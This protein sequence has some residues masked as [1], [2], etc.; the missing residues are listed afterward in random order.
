MTPAQAA[1]DPDVAA[2]PFAFCF[3][4]HPLRWAASVWRHEMEFGWREADAV[5]HDN[6]TDFLRWLLETRPE[7][8]CTASV[9]PYL[10]HCHFVGKLETLSQ[11]LCA[12]LTKAGE[13]FDPAALDVPPVNAS[14]NATIRSACVAPRE[15]L[16]AVLEAD[17]AFCRRFGYGGV[18]PELVGESVGSPWP[19]LR[20]RRPG[21]ADQAL[22]L[23]RPQFTY[24]LE[25]G[26]EVR[27]DPDRQRLQWALIKAIDGLDAPGRTAVVSEVDAYAAYLLAAKPGSDVTFVPAD[28][29]VTPTRLKSQLLDQPAILD[30]QS[31]HEDDAE[32]DFDTIMLLDSADLSA[33]LEGELLMTA[34]RLKPGGRLVLAA[35]VLRTDAQVSTTFDADWSERRGCRLVYRSLAEWRTVLGNC[36]FEDVEVIDEFDEAAQDARQR[37]AEALSAA[38]GSDPACLLGQALL[39]ARRASGDR[40]AEMR[41]MWVRRRLLSMDAAYDSLPA[42]VEARFLMLERQVE[43]ERLRRAQAEQ[44]VVDREADLVLARCETQAQRVEMDFLADKLRRTEQ[45]RLAVQVEL[46]E[47]KALVSRLGAGPAALNQGLDVAANDA[48]GANASAPLRWA[49]GFLPGRKASAQAS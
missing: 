43:T 41:D 13:T 8:P 23:S 45:Q 5:P 48:V 3:V 6:F 38:L 40:P 31:F 7:G 1:A 42:V 21:T 10:D 12:A 35:S 18:P 24:R 22:S 28:A 11:D 33:A 27:G 44:G 9:A 47:L 14:S 29:R 37:S 32:E 25:D 20:V 36:G 34:R 2:R 15:L 26:C 19:K 30:F 39:G 4:R 49:L 16:S 46:D 17:A